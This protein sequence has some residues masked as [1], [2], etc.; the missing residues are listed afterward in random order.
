MFKHSILEIKSRGLTYINTN[1]L[2]GNKSSYKQRAIKIEQDSTRATTSTSVKPEFTQPNQTAMF[3]LNYEQRTMM[4]ETNQICINGYQTH[5]PQQIIAVNQFTTNQ[6]II[7][8]GESSVM[9]GAQIPMTDN[10][11]KLSNI[12]PVNSNVYGTTT[13]GYYD[14]NSTANASSWY[15]FNVNSNQTGIIRL[16]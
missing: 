1:N 15:N 7:N 14:M 10:L 3:D 16:K 12:A 11:T 5:Q 13:G 6:Y 4:Q 8:R 9:G 2:P